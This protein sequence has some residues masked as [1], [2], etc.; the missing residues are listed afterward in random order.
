MKHILT[1]LILFASWTGCDKDMI[2]DWAPITFMI[3]VEDAQGNDMLDPANDNTWLIGTE[4]SFRNQSEVLD[5]ND[6]APVT[7]MILPMYEGAR[8]VKGTDNYFIA[9][10]E[11]STCN[12]IIRIKEIICF[13]VYNVII[14]KS[15]YIFFCPMIKCVIKM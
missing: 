12:S 11:F 14:K 7:K 10:G 8:V 1:I 3:Q 5:E 6:I 15:A 9:F 4:I 13:S 2:I